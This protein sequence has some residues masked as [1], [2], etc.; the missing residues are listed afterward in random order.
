M[1]HDGDH[2]DT[3]EP[4]RFALVTEHPQSDDVVPQQETSSQSPSHNN[5][6]EESSPQ[7]PSQESGPETLPGDEPQE[8]IQIV[9]DLPQHGTDKQQDEAFTGDDSFTTLE[10]IEPENFIPPQQVIQ[11]RE[12]IQIRH[13]REY[14]IPLRDRSLA[15]KL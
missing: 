4:R 12:A 2:T 11:A 3:S 6:P 14:F 5:S 10:D 7:R 13:G 8:G 15:N 1:S 9:P